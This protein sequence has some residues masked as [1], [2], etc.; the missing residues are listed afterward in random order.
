MKCGQGPGVADL[1]FEVQCSQ[2]QRATLHVAHGIFLVP[3]TDFASADVGVLDHIRPPD[4]TELVLLQ[5]CK[6]RFRLCGIYGS[7]RRPTVSNLV[8]TG[9]GASVDRDQGER[10]DI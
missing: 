7:P 5:R 1:G 2:R 6:S 4:R 9:Y 10:K 8:S 3:A